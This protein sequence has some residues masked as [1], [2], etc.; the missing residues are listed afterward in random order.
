MGLTIQNGALG[1]EH[2]QI[3]KVD[4]FSQNITDWYNWIQNITS[5][6]RF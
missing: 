1:A 3:K 4:F 6:S 2:E 5:Q